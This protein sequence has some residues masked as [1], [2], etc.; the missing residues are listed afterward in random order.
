MPL[1]NVHMKFDLQKKKNKKK[2]KRVLKAVIS[3]RIFL[4]G[5]GIL[6]NYQR[7]SIERPVFI[8]L[9]FNRLIAES[10]V[11][12]LDCIFQKVQSIVVGL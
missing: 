1:K 10:G 11:F 7:V 12:L 9:E 2:K 8:R 3:C 4:F 5:F 6:C